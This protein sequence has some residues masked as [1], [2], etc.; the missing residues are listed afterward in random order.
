M[1]YIDE[2]FLNQLFVLDLY[3]NSDSTYPG[4]DVYEYS[5]GNLAQTIRVIPPAP[6]IYFNVTL[7]SSSSVVAS[8]FLLE[9][10]MI[11]GTDLVRYREND[12]VTNHVQ[13]DTF[14]LAGSWA[15]K[16]V[17][18][19]SQCTLIHNTGTNEFRVIQTISNGTASTIASTNIIPTVLASQVGSTLWEVSNDCLRVRTDTNVYAASSTSTSFALV[20][21]VSS[22]IAADSDLTYVL[23]ASSILKYTSS[24]SSYTTVYTFTN[25][26]FSAS[27]TIQSYGG[28]I[29]IA[30]MLASA[31]NAYG[32]SDS[33]GVLT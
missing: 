8:Y 18:T 28:Q 7:P 26:T 29:I 13:I 14:P 4:Y 2:Y 24:N 20:S 23:T 33:N 6:S 19:N 15:V 12:N 16:A 31:V 30:E 21:A 11:V 5:F 9:W 22:W 3:F 32:F 1:T 17:S 27:S 25:A 10:T